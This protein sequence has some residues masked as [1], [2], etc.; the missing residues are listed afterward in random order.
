MIDPD[1][2]LGKAISDASDRELDTDR[3]F[4]SARLWR[5]YRIRPTGPAEELEARIYD[6]EWEPGTE[7]WR[8]WT[9]V[10]ALSPKIR[11]RHFFRSPRDFTRDVGEEE[12]RRLYQ[13]HFADARV[14]E[15]AA[16]LRERGI[17]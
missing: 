3:K 5:S 13:E 17:I 9:L 11:V 10:R 12:A 2:M 14:D 1:G 7:I 6:P 16:R 8:R 15:L 4:F